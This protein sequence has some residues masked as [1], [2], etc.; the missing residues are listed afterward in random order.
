[1][2]F[3]DHF[4]IVAGVNHAIERTIMIQMPIVDIWFDIVE[5]D[6]LTGSFMPSWRRVIEVVE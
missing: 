5:P 1:M 6:L 2:A 4:E 3:D